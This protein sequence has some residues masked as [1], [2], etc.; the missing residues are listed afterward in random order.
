MKARLLQSAF[1]HTTGTNSTRRI[2]RPQAR[3]DSEIWLDIAYHL[4][5]PHGLDGLSEAQS[6]PS[7]A[8]ARIACNAKLMRR[9]HQMVLGGVKLLA[10]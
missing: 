5:K 4:V 1:Q 6:A 9:L 7:A 8:D 2:E 3:C 10:I